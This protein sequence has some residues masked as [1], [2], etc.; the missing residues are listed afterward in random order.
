MSKKSIVILSIVGVVV[1]TCLLSV[2]GI[3]SFRNECVSFDKTITAQVSDMKAKHNEYFTKVKEAAQVPEHQLDKLKTFYDK[4]VAGRSAEG[5]M[6]KWISENNPSINQETFVELQRIIASGRSEIYNIQ[7]I[8]IDT[9]REYN[10]YI[11]VFPNTLVN[12]LFFN[13]TSKE[14]TLPIASN[15]DEIFK[16]KED[17]V[18][19]I[20]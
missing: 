12:R 6:F 17:K 3:V 4:I 10:T 11:V 8:H 9:V 18:I 13:F 19:E 1:L 14:P 16:T 2:S 5:A 7:K 20:F 15:V